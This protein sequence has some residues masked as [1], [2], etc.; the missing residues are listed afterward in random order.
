MVA[1]IADGAQHVHAG[2]GQVVGMDAVI[3]HKGVDAV[4][5]K[6]WATGSASSG[7]L[8]WKPPPGN[9][10]MAGRGRYPGTV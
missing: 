6:N 1:Q 10:T 3:E 9:T 4:H 7:A 2:I 5:L 8:K